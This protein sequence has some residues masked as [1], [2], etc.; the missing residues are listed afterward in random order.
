MNKT[1]LITG[2][3]SGFGKL[4]AITFHKNHWNVIATMRKPEKETELNQLDNV[5][6]LRMDVTERA[7]VK[8]ATIKGVA[9]FGSIDVLVNNAGYGAVGYLEEAS[10]E[11]I[12][13]QMDT[14]FTGTLYTIQESLPIMRRQ[15]E[16]VIINVTS[17]AGTIG[18]PMHSLYNASKF[19]V[20]GLS[21]SLRYELE[22][23]NIQV[24]TIAPGAFKTGFGGAI[25]YTEGN[26]KNDLE[27]YRLKFQSHYNQVVALPPKPFGFGDPQIVADLIYKAS[28][29]KTADK[30]FVGKDAKMMIPMKKIMPKSYFTKTLKDSLLPK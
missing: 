27:D 11:D 28:T 6:L 20:E 29:Q 4:A 26:K 22:P 2:A 30:I 23:F 17:M 1:V 12:R 5:L 16:G 24:K 9:R 18:L 3:S 8:Q 10:D 14:N 7:S 15:K 21:E 13:R 19:A 25:S